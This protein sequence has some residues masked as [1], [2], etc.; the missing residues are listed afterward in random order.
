MV[1]TYFLKF[2]NL[3]NRA[4][5]GVFHLIK[6]PTKKNTKLLYIFLFI[7]RV[8]GVIHKHENHMQ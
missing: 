7:S 1:S 6:T 4:L 2:Q 3:V 5:R 8:K